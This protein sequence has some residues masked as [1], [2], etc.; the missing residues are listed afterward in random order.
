MVCV[1]RRRIPIQASTDLAVEAQRGGHGHPRLCAREHIVAA[2]IS[3]GGVSVIG[4]RIGRRQVAHE[5]VFGGELV[6]ALEVL[7]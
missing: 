7:T 1:R 6:D 5:T 4:I 2:F 3:V